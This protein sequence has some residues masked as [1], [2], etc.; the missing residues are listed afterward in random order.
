MSSRRKCVDRRIPFGDI[1]GYRKSK[2]SDHACYSICKSACLSWKNTF[3]I[4]RTRP[5]G[6][7]IFEETQKARSCMSKLT[8]LV[9]DIYLV[10][11]LLL[12]R[13][14]LGVSMRVCTPFILLVHPMPCLQL[15]N[16]VYVPKT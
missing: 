15:H 10:V 11:H 5:I 12:V 1:L 7:S 8:K 9:L 6:S 3:A 14:S 16:M 2:G 13:P 4:N